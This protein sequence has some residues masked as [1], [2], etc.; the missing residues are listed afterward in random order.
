MALF[1]H[2]KI[3]TLYRQ[4]KD[5]QEVFKPLFY[6]IYQ[7]SDRAAF[8]LLIDKPGIII[9]D[10]VLD[11]VKELMKISHPRLKLTSAEQ[12]ELALQ[13]IKPFELE[14]YGV[15]VYYPWSNR[16]VHIVD[17]KEFIELR[18]SRNQYKI[19]R[20]ERDLLSQKKI[21]VIGL[22]VGQSVSLTLA[23]ERV[24][25]ELRLADFDVLE[26]TNL[27]RIR[28]GIHNL[29]L[30]KVYVVA[31]EIA[32]IDPFITVRCFSEGLSESNMDAFFTEGGKLD[33]LVEESDGFD[34]KVLSRYK[35]K[36]LGVPVIMEAND[37]CMIDVERFDLEPEREILHGLLQHLNI[38]TLK[39]LKT[40]EEKIPYMLDV[41]GIE[42]ASPLLKASML[43]IEQTITTWPQLASSTTMGGGVCADTVRR[44][45]L[46]QYTGSGRFHIDLEDLIKTPTL[47]K[48]IPAD[49][50]VVRTATS[51]SKEEMLKIA[52]TYS[53]QKLNQVLALTADQLQTLIEAAILAPSG[54]NMQPWQWV[55]SD[56]QLFLFHDVARAASLL[57]FDHLASYIA[58]GTSLENL[59]LKAHELNLNLSTELFPLHNEKRLIAKIYFSIEQQE[60]SEPHS[61]DFLAP[62]IPLRVTNRTLAHRQP[63]PS[64]DLQA[65]KDI[66]R[67]VEGAEIKIFDTDEQLKELADIIAKVERI[68]IMHPRGHQD[69]NNEIRWTPQENEEKR[70]GVDIATIDITESEK[71]GFIVAK[72]WKVIAYLK[73]WKKGMA[74]ERMSRKSIEA[75]SVLGLITMPKYQPEDFINGGRAVQRVW[76]AANSKNISFQPQSPATF[77]FARLIQGDGIE[78]DQETQQELKELHQRFIKLTG[79]VSSEKEIFLFRLSIAQEPKVKSLRREINDV[80]TVNQQAAS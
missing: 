12:E 43:E 76:L 21:G 52:S 50:T 19:T 36:S 44:I 24:G 25:G 15:W 7:E 23:M 3:N 47:S 32:E 51:L 61:V 16:L 4:Q 73:K 30:H 66:A 74:F 79:L 77:F 18:T 70:D 80:L 67:T 62:Y 60:E 33:L 75:A 49:Q 35:A 17:E 10:Y 26:L 34:I 42:T 28:T 72:D 65:I 20:E 63:I 56:K 71:A 45:F 6:R 38:D 55:Y 37:R 5:L 27:N 2:E 53:S 46:N 22:S 29:G 11:Q 1:L 41:L 68:R 59:T 13:H 8:S 58:L 39:S 54:G 78:L 40:N 64:N 31:R 9:T 14:D 69:F 48:E 57:D